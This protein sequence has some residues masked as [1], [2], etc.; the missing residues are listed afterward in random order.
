[1]RCKRI[2]AERSSYPIPPS[3]HNIQNISYFSDGHIPRDSTYITN[4]E[5]S[6]PLPLYIVMT[7][8]AGIGIASAVLFF[9]FNI[10]FRHNK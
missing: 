1:M 2:A 7:A 3:K 8:A 6:I 10:I 9:V 5:V 4:E